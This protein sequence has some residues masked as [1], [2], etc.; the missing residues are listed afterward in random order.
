MDRKEVSKMLEDEFRRAKRNSI[1][2]KGKTVYLYDTIFLPERTRLTLRFNKVKSK[3]CQGV[4]LCDMPYTSTKTRF[5]VEG[6]TGSS[7]QLWAHTSPKVVEIDIYA[8]NGKINVYNTWDIGNGQCRSQLEG[9]GMLIEVS[10]DGKKRYYRCNDGHPR[11]TFKH[12]EF[13]IEIVPP[14]NAGKNRKIG[15]G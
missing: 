11:T 15:T 8:P 9:A 2:Y 7:V 3:W 10:E 1:M 6:E 14:E 12:L 4:C 5:T 13:S